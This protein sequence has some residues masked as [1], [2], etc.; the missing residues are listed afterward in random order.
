MNKPPSSTEKRQNF[1]EGLLGG[2]LFIHLW[3]Y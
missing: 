1:K 2:G 3:Y